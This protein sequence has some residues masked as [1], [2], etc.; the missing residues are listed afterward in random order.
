MAQNHTFFRYSLVPQFGQGFILGS[1]WR[2]CL[3]D[4]LME[5][6]QGYT[7]QEPSEPQPTG[8]AD[9]VAFL[10]PVFTLEV[11]PGY[12]TVFPPA[13]TLYTLTYAYKHLRQGVEAGEVIAKLGRLGTTYIHD[14]GALDV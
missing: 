10:N 2:H 8:W 7:G 3:I 6:E 12:F 14:F 13:E 5:S 4:C 1:L 11:E 9:I